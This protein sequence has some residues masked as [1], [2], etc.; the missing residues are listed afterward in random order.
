MPMTTDE[1][2]LDAF[3]GC[4]LGGAVG[5]ALGAPVEFMKRR[6]IVMRFGEPGIRDY[7]END[8]GVI[9]ALI[10]DDTQMTLFTAEGLFRAYMRCRTQTVRGFSDAFVNV[11]AHAY[12]RW[13]HTQGETSPLLETDKLDGWLIKHR[14]LFAHRAPGNTCLSALRDMRRHFGNPR[15]A[16]NDSKG[17]G[18]VM[19]VAPVGMF[20][21]SG[22]QFGD[23][24]RRERLAFETGI[25]LAAITH[26][27][28]TGYLA[29]GAF[30]LIVMLLLEGQ[31]LRQAV[32]TTVDRLVDY[33]QYEETYEA[34][35][36]A[37]AAATN[38][39]NDSDTLAALGEGWVAEEALAIALY[40]ALSTDETPM[41]LESYD[42][43]D[44]T[45]Q[46]NRLE[47]GIVL[48]VNHSGDSD[49]TGAICGNLLGAM[50]GETSIPPRWLEPLELREVVRETADDLAN[51]ETWGVG[52]NVDP[53]KERF[54]LERYPGW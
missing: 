8:D 45:H 11:T 7:P 43:K 47:R 53:D 50:Y 13:L 32:R 24:A 19:R 33:D 10:T 36:K 22:K 41:S 23:H 5:D 34:I 26:G 18:G 3:R 39:P 51:Y 25:Q 44:Q 4:L 42:R 38:S 12:L 21:A 14:E 40:A 27:H 15:V 52:E 29:S 48:A 2:R 16:Y 9:E 20:F 30:A 17:C 49:S 1:N 28:P 46:Q 35:E 37:V 31:S 6:Q 54:Y